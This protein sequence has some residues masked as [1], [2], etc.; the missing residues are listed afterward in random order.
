MK[1]K[2][3]CKDCEHL[4]NGI[5]PKCKA[6]KYEDVD[7]EDPVTGE[8]EVLKQMIGTEYCHSKNYNYA[9]P[10]YEPK[11][12]AITKLKSIMKRIKDILS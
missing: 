10:D 11:I 2:V 7:Y 9:C 5:Y 3:Y 6:L 8:K 1:E 12:P 4:S